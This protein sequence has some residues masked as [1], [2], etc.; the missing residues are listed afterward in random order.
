MDRFFEAFEVCRKRGMFKVVDY[1][2]ENGIDKPHFYT[3][4]KNRERGYFEVGWL[5]PL[6]VKCRVSPL[7]LLT[8]R[9]EMFTGK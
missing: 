9:G 1:C 4:R 5:V 2:R 6:V 3:Q 7:W 8:G